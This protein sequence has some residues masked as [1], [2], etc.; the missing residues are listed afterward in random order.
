MKLTFFSCGGTIAGLP[1]LGAKVMTMEVL[2]RAAKIVLRFA[3]RPSIIELL[4]QIQRYPLKGEW[5]TER[6]LN[7]FSP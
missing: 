2:S 5:L 6:V 3:C 4:K 7:A 1:D